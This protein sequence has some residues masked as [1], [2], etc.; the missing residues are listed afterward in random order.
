LTKEGKKRM[1]K[2]KII[3]TSLEVVLI[4]ALFIRTGYAAEAKLAE[5]ISSKECWEIMKKNQKVILLDVRTQ[6]EFQF[7]GYIEGSYN[8]PYWFLSP[9]FTPKDKE[10]EFAKGKMQ[11]AP[12]SRYQFYANTDFLTHVKKLVKPSDTVIVYC[13]ASKRSAKAADYL[14][15][16]G[17]ENVYNI[18]EGFSRGWKKQN[19]PYKEML[20]VE[21]IDPKFI[22][23]P[24]LI[25]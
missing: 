5:N 2:A 18:L 3:L 1:K 11:K 7:L 25:K 17:Y 24:D 9:S 10:F 12:M 20:K 15:N 23:P 8:I 13:G 22:Y 16:A 19:M 21:T 14:V 6:A 4:T